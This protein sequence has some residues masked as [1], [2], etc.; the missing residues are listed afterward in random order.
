MALSGTDLRKLVGV[1]GELYAPDGSSDYPARVIALV[2]SLIGVGSCSYNH[3][4]GSTALAYEIQPAEVVAFPDSY[5]LFELHLPEHPLLSY[6]A[7]TGDGSACRV[8]D[9]VSDR[10]FRSLG[11][12]RDF[13]LPADVDY[14][15]CFMAP[16][17]GGGE[18]AV[19]LNRKGRDFSA[20]ERDLLEL[21]RPHVAQAA[22]IAALL[23]QPVPWSFDESGDRPRLTPRQ[24]RIVQLVADG[25]ADREVGRMLGISTRTVHAH[26]QHIY[27]ALDVTSRTEALARL[28]ELSLM[29]SARRARDTGRS[30]IPAP[31]LRG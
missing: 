25:Y 12:Y 27:R 21:L 16:H 6:V 13:Y 1:L 31:D 5:A 15:M 4:D 28:R 10:Q 14:Q 11:L 9:I 30:A 22:A 26:L 7:A 19:A 8:S 18:I 3:L 17:P 24:K 20:E 2:S 29:S 23:S